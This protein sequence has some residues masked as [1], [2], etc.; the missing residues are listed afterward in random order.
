MGYEMISIVIPMYNVENYIERCL[1]SVLSQKYQNFEVVLIDD[2]STD[3]T[4][5]IV[6]TFF[7]NH[8]I[9]HQIINQKNQGVSTARNKGID[10][11]NGEYICFLDSDDMIR[12]DFLSKM[13]EQIIK[14][15]SDVVICEYREIHDNE[16]SSMIE[17]LISDEIHNARVITNII[18]LKGF[19]YRRIN[20]GVWSILIKMNILRKYNIRFKEGYR[21]SEDVH[22]I[23]RIFNKASAITILKEQLYLYRIRPTSVM[24][25]VDASRLDGLELMNDLEG[26]FLRENPEFSRI[27]IKFGVARWVWATVWQLAKATPSSRDFIEYNSILN[28]KQYFK[29]LIF[30][31]DI[32]VAS[33]SMVFLISMNAY[34]LLIKVVTNRKRYRK[35][36]CTFD[37]S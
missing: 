25:K 17:P 37:C 12:I 7:S 21:Y 14:N 11:A 26:Y 13:Y 27:F 36:K 30:F 15:N 2:G 28:V 8:T 4:M 35:I 1:Y 33:L 5:E 9:S 20:T 22:F 29:K 16:I 24:G 6:E 31:P 34:Y 18:A 19:L 3:N 23:Y 32:R 10:V